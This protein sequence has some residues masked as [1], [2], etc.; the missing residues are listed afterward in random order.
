MKTIVILIFLLKMIDF[1]NVSMIEL[2]P[3]IDYKQTIFINEKIV[4][5]MKELNN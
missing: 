4:E 1:I 5:K 3:K 2:L